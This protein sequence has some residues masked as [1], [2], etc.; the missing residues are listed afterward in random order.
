MSEEKLDLILTVVNEI[1]GR[2]DKLDS[3]MGK[4]ESDFKDF[5]KQV[6]E[7][8]STLNNRIDILEKQLL[9]IGVEL[10]E[11]IRREIGEVRDEINRLENTIM[12]EQAEKLQD[13]VRVR[14][15]EMRVAKLEEKII[16]AA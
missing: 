11:E 16:L 8:L 1:K 12:L 4:L 2:V 10:K 3:R 6:I 9:A 15:L 5:R 14:Q 13:R 7:A